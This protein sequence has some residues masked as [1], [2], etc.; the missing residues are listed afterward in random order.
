MNEHPTPARVPQANENVPR[1]MP[2]KTRLA[3]VATHPVP[4]SV[5]LYRA[6][7]R[8][9]DLDVRA[10]FA[11]RVGLDKT[12]DPGMGVEIAWTTD[13][14]GGYEHEFL[15][16]AEHIPHTGFRVVDNKGVGAA[17]A[18]FRPDVV[19]M[20]GYMW[21]TALR[22][23][24]WCRL[25]RV[26]AMMI[27]DGS[28]H[29][30]TGAMAGR[31]KAV[32]LPMI[33]RQFSAFLG[34]GDANE[35]YLQTFGVPRARIF[36][37]PVIVDEGFWAYRARREA[38][39]T[40]M[41]SE[42]GLRENDLVVLFVGKLI[43]RKRPG[44]LLAALQRLAALP[45]TPRPV[46]VLFA[47][48]GEQRAELEAVAARAQLPARFLGF[49]NIDRLPTYYC[50][51]DVLA[52]PAEIEVYGMIVLEAVILGLPLVVSDKVGAV[53]PTS[54]ARPGENALIHPCGDVAAL[55]ERLVRLASEPETL[56]RLAE[57]SH[58]ISA[59]H[60]GRMSVAGTRAA[61]A[62]CLGNQSAAR[63]GPERRVV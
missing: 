28:L 17:L 14:L 20:N 57:A 8:Q 32:V 27:S 16:G 43:D 56:V 62:H 7:A 22:T 24:A 44:D 18:R 23:L 13:L 53:G 42:L 33:L 50:A 37:V 19:L 54:A 11:S 1:G 6:L 41:R 61:I 34:I 15:P 31:L 25:Q 45:P 35:R 2:N 58:R 59:D 51:A 30:G 39:R 52:H 48:D 38:T 47:G 12:L 29:S 9:D 40:A 26:P 21:K 55:T 3:V 10:F 63:S 60:D 49:V 36:R 46:Q 5:P 4:Y